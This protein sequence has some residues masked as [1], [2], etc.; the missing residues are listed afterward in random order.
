[1]FFE[2]GESKGEGKGREREG[3]TKR[4]LNLGSLSSLPSPRVKN[5]FKKIKTGMVV[6]DY[7]FWLIN[8]ID[9]TFG[10]YTYS[11]QLNNLHIQQYIHEKFLN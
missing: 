3:V 10:I 9:K 1:M 8:S 7:K 11:S 4:G 6:S 2:K 5:Y